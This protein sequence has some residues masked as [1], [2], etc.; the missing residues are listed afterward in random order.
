M[1]NRI[2]ILLLLSIPLWAQA[3]RPT[4]LLIE[5][6]NFVEYLGD[7]DEV[8]KHGTD[9]NITTPRLP[10]ALFPANLLGDIVSVN[11]QP[12]KGFVIHNARAI[13]ATTASIAGRPIADVTRGS[14]RQQY[15]EILGADGTAIG[16]ILAVGM[17][18]GA[19]PPGT[20]SVMTASANYAIIGG[21][22]AF[23]GVRGQAGQAAQI[24]VARPASVQE[25]PSR[26]RV[27]GGGRI[28]FAL[29]FYPMVYPAV[30]SANGTPAI[31]HANDFQIVSTA[32]PAA[33]IL[34]LYAS[35]LGPTR[36]SADWGTPFPA[37]PV[38]VVNSPVEVFVNGAPAEVLGAVGY[39]G[40]VDGYQV[41]FRVPADAA[42][43]MAN[44][45]V[46][47]AWTQSAAVSIPIQ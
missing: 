35:G 36:P 19:A 31:A 12:A 41:N 3:P 17:Q 37:T 40:A 34:A 10:N 4:T 32:R 11:G 7:S 6:D 39:P 29:T 38:S 45:V 1:Q 23:L 2:W 8:M 24:R 47:S 5:V 18:G 15:F 20:P 13:G 46:S 28:R 42:K 30:L 16:T 27:N 14:N 22:G 21:T 9:P 43:G 33:E 26:R 44:V 25:D